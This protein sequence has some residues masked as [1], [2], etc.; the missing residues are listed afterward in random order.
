MNI[1]TITDNRNT[2]HAPQSFTLEVRRRKSRKGLY[3]NASEVV[4]DALHLLEDQERQRQLELRRLL[5]QGRASGVSD[6][7]GEAVLDR[8]ETKYRSMTKRRRA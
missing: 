4:R 7:P 1:T 3:N 5:D 6:E 8:L 2:A